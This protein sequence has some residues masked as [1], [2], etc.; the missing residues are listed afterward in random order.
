MN[1]KELTLQFL[2]EEGYCPQETEFGIAF[3]CE[4]KNFL[5]IQ[6]DDDE[7]R[8]G[9]MF[10]WP[11]QPVHL[12]H[13][14][15]TDLRF[16]DLIDNAGPFAEFLIALDHDALADVQPLGNADVVALRTT[17]CH[18]CAMNRIAVSDCPYKK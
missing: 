7:Q 8:D 17:D 13:L 1:L 4:G 6:D 2:Q 3:K 5:F 10:Q 15:F 9:I 12:F 14:R 18:L 16:N 11:F